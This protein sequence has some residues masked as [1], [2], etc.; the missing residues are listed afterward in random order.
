MSFYQ[1][2]QPPE[3]ECLS[4]EIRSDLAYECGIPIA[5]INQRFSWLDTGLQIHHGQGEAPRFKVVR[6][7]GLR[8]AEF[9]SDGF[10]IE[11]FKVP[12]QTL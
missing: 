8:V 3:V 2:M 1:M 5:I 9:T 11:Q 10:K 4:Y 7:P 12:A 6:K